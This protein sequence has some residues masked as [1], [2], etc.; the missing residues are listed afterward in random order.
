MQDYYYRN[1]D[2]EFRFFRFVPDKQHHGEHCGASAERG[3]K[4]KR[5][6]G[7]TPP[8]LYF[9]IML[10]GNAHDGGYKR[11]HRNVRYQNITQGLVH[12]IRRTF[13]IRSAPLRR[14]ARCTDD[15]C[16]PSPTRT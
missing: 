11:D 2:H 9:G 7:H 6:F 10:V 15:R 13:R 14:T 8:S 5:L 16:D 4:E 12:V 1:S 3:K